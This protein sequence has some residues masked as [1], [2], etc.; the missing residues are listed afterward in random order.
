[1]D[2]IR[3]GEFIKEL[4]IKKGLTQTELGEILGVS[5]KAV[6]K[7]ERGINM[8]DVSL[9]RPLC[10]ILGIDIDE[11]M[12]AN[13]KEKKKSMK[14]GLALIIT[15]LIIIGTVL[16]FVLNKKSSTGYNILVK[17]TNDSLKVVKS[18]KDYNIWYLNTNNVTISYNN[19]TYD[20]ISAIENNKI[21]L[22]DLKTY[23]IKSNL[24]RKYLNDGGTIVFIDKDYSII[25]CKTLE[26]NNDIYVGPSNTY[27]VLEDNYCGHMFKNDCKFRRTYYVEAIYPDDNEYYINATIKE[28]QGDI[29]TVRIPISSH[30]E[31]NKTYEFTFVTY[32]KFE[33]NLVNIFENSILIST[34][35]TDKTGLEQ[36]Y[37]NICVSEAR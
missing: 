9:F 3:I 25:M 6:S 29:K 10:D 34:K 20:F 31:E 18:F 8:P 11:L 33:D 12:N 7:W 27:E 22:E 37:D 32:K 23:L 36:V 13:L 24:D 15:L 21:D 4:R 5:Y 2:Q 19:V 17:K 35:E 26:H 30:I 14:K 16:I 28:F 1:M